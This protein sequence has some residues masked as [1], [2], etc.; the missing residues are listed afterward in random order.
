MG[1]KVES[2][3]Y[4]PGYYTMRDFSADA[5]S[6]SW[7]FYYNDLRSMQH[8]SGFASTSMDGYPEDDK[9]MLKQTMLKHETIFR[10]QVC[11]LHRLY[12]KQKDL[13]VELRNKDIYRY[14]FPGETSQSGSFSSQ[15]KSDGNGNIWNIHRLPVVSSSSR[16]SV[17]GNNHFQNSLNILE[18]SGLQMGPFPTINGG[19]MKECELLDTRAK[20]IP[21]TMI[22][23]HL[24]ADRYVDGEDQEWVK[25]GNVAQ[26]SSWMGVSFDINRA[27][28]PE[29][30]VKLTLGTGGSPSCQEGGSK[31]YPHLQNGSSSHSLADLN[32]PVKGNNIN[33][34][35][36]SHSVGFLGRVADHEDI[37]GH[38]L[39]TKLNPVFPGPPRNFFQDDPRNEKASSNNLHIETGRTESNMHP[40]GLTSNN[41]RLT[42][43]CETLKAEGKKS[44][45]HQP[46][47][48][49]GQ[50]KQETCFKEKST[51]CV[52]ISSGCSSLAHSTCTGSM[53]SHV[54]PFSVVSHSD[55][56]NAASQFLSPWR[57]PINSDSQ[58]LDSSAILNQRSSIQSPSTSGEKLNNRKGSGSY[59][60]IGNQIS[61]SNGLNANYRS[62]SSAAPH[63][64]FHTINTDKQHPP[65][66]A[67][68]SDKSFQVHGPEK[69]F[70]GLNCNGVKSTEEINLNLEAPNGLRDGFVP[71]RHT[72][73]ID[74]EEDRKRDKSS[75]DISWLKVKPS[76][77]GLLNT[78]R[79]FPGVD[80]NPLPGNHKSLA[81]GSEQKIEEQKCLSRD[82]RLNFLSTLPSRD[83]E[84]QRLDSSES[85]SVKKIL[86]FP[87]LK[88]PQQHSISSS[89]I[90]HPEK[91]ETD[92]IHD[93]IRDELSLGNS[94]HGV[95]LL[96]LEKPPSVEDNIEEKGADNNLVGLRGHINLNSTI[97]CL[98]ESV[99]LEISFKDDVRVN[100]RI[101]ADI[102]LE[103]PILVQPEKPAILGDRLNSNQPET[104][105]QLLTQCDAEG[106][107]EPPIHLSQQ[108][109]EDPDESLAR[110]AAQ[111]I[112]AM[113]SSTCDQS[114][115]T[116][117]P[118]FPTSLSNS[119]L[120]LA[121]LVSSKAG[122]LSSDDGDGYD[123][124][125]AMTL[126]L[127]ESKVDEY[128]RSNVPQWE[129][130]EEETSFAPPSLTRPRRGQARKRRQRRDFQK[131]ILPGLTSLTRHEVTE[132][133]QA[134]G[135]IMRAAGCAWQMRSTRRNTTRGRR[136]T[137]GTVIIV[138]DD[139]PTVTVQPTPSTNTNEVEVEGMSIKGWGRTRRCRRQRYP[140]GN[141]SMTMNLV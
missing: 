53:T 8:Y 38:R 109:V 58:R 35:T 27:S 66:G 9:E 42:P 16:P 134:F 65:N 4:L 40:F 56:G 93:K 118:A 103:A 83:N 125:E 92:A 124:Y 31:S 68:L 59:S 126:K 18:G 62:E 13:M 80:F 79:S 28:E 87:L 113:S 95:R 51:S 75:Q 20:K 3:N 99:S 127:T 14:S 30:D 140:Q 139:D 49:P 101:G 91:S 57:K 33:E 32:E 50:S 128:H 111:C 130:Q 133:L 23:L 108:E 25:G 1:T 119:L 73:I 121:D 94:S 72:V 123:S 132:D 5:N 54:H 97:T 82:M 114:Y 78:T 106:P 15:M 138:E 141:I 29:S 112:V 69:C 10:N 39:S 44:H 96:D 81:S 60:L 76:E 120:L 41:E 61:Y 34:G 107:R 43:P 90:S 2:K 45:I 55:N 88:K 129:N 117:C 64:Y 11:E 115:D 135:E 52:N 86:G 12:Q 48:L 46:L 77:N 89:Y 7:S 85:R 102:D 67:I 22:D 70:N 131:D 24:P 104:A 37:Q 17:S 136:T 21:R 122:I 71:R 47:I 19:N 74:L 98:E 26:S 116:M 63:L 105:V 6:R 36:G 84:A 137:K 100:K 110:V